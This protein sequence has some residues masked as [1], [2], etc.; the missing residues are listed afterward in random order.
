MESV[1]EKIVRGFWNAYNQNNVDAMMDYCTENCY[2]IYPSLSRLEKGQ[3]RKDLKHEKQGFPDSNVSNLVTICQDNMVAAEFD[4]KAT[5]TGEYHSQPPTFNRYE[6]P[7]CL[8]FELIDGMINQ[9]RYYF[10]TS[11]WE[12]TSI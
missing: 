3:W 2:A 11:L 9:V 1:N 4:W 6:I 5:N 7:C 12:Q 8:I 10:N